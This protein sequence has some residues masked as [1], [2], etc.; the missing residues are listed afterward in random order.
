M[1]DAILLASD[2]AGKARPDRV[3][4]TWCDQIGAH[5]DTIATLGRVSREHADVPALQLT[6][7]L[8]DDGIEALRRDWH[9]AVRAVLHAQLDVEQPQEVVKL[10]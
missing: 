6:H 9:V 1:L 2:A 3:W 8:A 7:H 10:G 5:P 4:I